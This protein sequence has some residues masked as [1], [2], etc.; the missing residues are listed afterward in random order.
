MHFNTPAIIFLCPFQKLNCMHDLDTSLKATKD[1]DRTVCAH[2][3]CLCGPQ[4]IGFIKQVFSFGKQPVS[5]LTETM[6]IQNMHSHCL[7]NNRQYQIRIFNIIPSFFCIKK[8]KWEDSCSLQVCILKLNPGMKP[9]QNWSWSSFIFTVI[10]NN[11]IMFIKLQN[12]AKLW[13]SSIIKN[14]LP[15]TSTE[16]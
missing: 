12:A 7:Y 15:L 1:I 2:L 14:S 16:S 11:T 6:L 13:N 10:E 8:A 3:S 9:M 4:K 5:I